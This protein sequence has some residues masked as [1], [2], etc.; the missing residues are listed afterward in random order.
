MA[1]TDPSESGRAIR[2]SD[3]RQH[4]HEGLL[5]GFA[6]PHEEGVRLVVPAADGLEAALSNSLGAWNNGGSVLLAHPDVDL[7]DKL[8]AAERIHGK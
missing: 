3:G 4:L 5:T 7:T 6:A 8:L 2:G 1:H